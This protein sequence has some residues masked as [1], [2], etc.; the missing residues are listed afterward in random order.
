MKKLFLPISVITLVLI[1]AGILIFQHPEAETTTIGRYS[2]VIHV[3]IIVLVLVYILVLKELYP[4]KRV[5]RKRMNSQNE[6]S[7]K[8][9]RFHSIS[10][11]FYGWSYCL[12]K[13][14]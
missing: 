14:V 7:K 9:P 5:F 11:Y 8:L 13:I 3:G 4:L 10:H 12:S 1:I 2:E 6:L